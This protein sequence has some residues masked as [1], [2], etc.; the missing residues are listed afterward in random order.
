M[1]SGNQSNLR[2]LHQELGARDRRIMDDVIRFR[3][4]TNEAIQRLHLSNAKTNATTKVTSRL[5]KQGWLVGYQYAAM[6]Q[7]FVPGTKAIRT[8]GLPASRS[9]VLGPQALAT[10]LAIIEY[11]LFAP[12]RL[13][14]M[15]DA[16][17]ITLLADNSK[18]YRTLSH[19][20]E[21][22]PVDGSIKIIRV[23]LG[24]APSHIAKKLN[25][26]V[27]KRIAHLTYAS[28]IANRK[29]VFV[30]LTP[31]PTKKIG[32]ETAIRKRV[33]PNGIRFSVNVTPILYT[34]LGG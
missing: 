14:I 29:L 30:V 19:A 3:L 20:V 15:T 16:E 5:V 23:D 8:F 17:L 22:V 24:G 32:I 10:Y 27:Q 2:K 18:E 12:D 6:S 26:D 25:A 21:Q 4:M 31:S 1:N 28:L 11:V 13:R 7:Y 34:L 9:R 33:W